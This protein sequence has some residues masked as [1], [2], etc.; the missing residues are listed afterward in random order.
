MPKLPSDPTQDFDGQAL[1]DMNDASTRA[2]LVGQRARLDK[3]EAAAAA[4]T[5]RRRRRNILDLS[6]DDNEASWRKLMP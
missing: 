2:L 6:D 4:R 3:E 5:P 1:I